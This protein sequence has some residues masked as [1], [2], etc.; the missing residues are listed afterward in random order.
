LLGCA[1]IAGTMIF[2]IAQVSTLTRFLALFLIYR[3]QNGNEG[4]LTHT[5][6]TETKSILER[7]WKLYF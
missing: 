1:F 2:S 4:T 3:G 7:V 5:Y 6:T